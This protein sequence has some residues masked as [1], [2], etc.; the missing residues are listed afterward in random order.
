MLAPVRRATR[1]NTDG[2]TFCT[3]TTLFFCSWCCIQ[4]VTARVVSTT[5]G[6][7]DM[8]RRILEPSQV[9]KYLEWIERHHKGLVN[10]NAFM[11]V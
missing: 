8:M 9:P 10:Y 2:L 6:L 11:D 3:T 1:C 4:N 5:V 7:T